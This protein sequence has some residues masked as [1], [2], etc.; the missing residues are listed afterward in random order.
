M[1]TFNMEKEIEYTR[2]GADFYYLDCKRKG[3]TPVEVHPLLSYLKDDCI[4]LCAGGGAE[5]TRIK[6]TA[7]ESR[8]D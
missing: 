3:I 8:Q 4:V 6:T 7:L 5:I 2:K 1:S